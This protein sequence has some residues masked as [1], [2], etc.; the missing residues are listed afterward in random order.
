MGVWGIIPIEKGLENGHT[1][2]LKLGSIQYSK[3]S[4]LSF[5]LLCCNAKESCILIPK[6]NPRYLTSLF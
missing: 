2:C 5:S 4:D 6:L 3:F 1:A